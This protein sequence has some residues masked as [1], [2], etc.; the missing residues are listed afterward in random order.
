[1][2]PRRFAPIVQSWQ[3]NGLFQ[4]TKFILPSAPSIPVTS[5][6]GRPIPAWFDIRGE[7]GPRVT[8]EALAAQP[9]DEEGLLHSRDY[10]LSLS[11]SRKTSGSS[12]SPA[13]GPIPASR[14]IMGGF[15]QGG[16][17]ALLTGVSAEAAAGV[18]LGGVFCLSGY[19]ALGDAVRKG[20]VGG[21]GGGGG[22]GGGGKEHDTEVLMVHGDRDPIMNLKWAEESAGVVRGLGY[23]VELSVVPINQEVLAKVT[24]FI[25]KVQGKGRENQHDEL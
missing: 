13:S 8:F 22:G 16:V 10:F 4:D 15:S 7:G 9:Q 2:P 14:I 19:L 23:D 5:A 17:M 21:D 24:T 25:N 11:S 18:E 12:S 3:D 1:M 20:D 6:H